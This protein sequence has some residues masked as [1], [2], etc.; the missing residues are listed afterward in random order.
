[1]SRY[2]GPRVKISRKLG[3]LPGLTRNTRTYWFSSF[4]NNRNEIG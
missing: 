2:R 1:M 3:E 4:T